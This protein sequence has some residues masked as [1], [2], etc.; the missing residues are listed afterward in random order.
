MTPSQLL[1]A[2]RDLI[3]RPGATAAG[4]WPRTAA[5][6]ARQALEAAVDA[7]WAAASETAG[8]DRAAM[9]SQLICLPSYADEAVARQI[10]FTYAAL[11]GAC[12]F[13]PYELAPTATEL[14]RWIN[15]VET[16][17]T[18][19]TQAGRLVGDEF[20]YVAIG[21]AEVL[22]G[23]PRL[24][25]Q[26]DAGLSQFVDG[27]RQVAH[28]EAGNRTGAEMLL[29]GVAVAK[30]LDVAATWELE[31]PE[32]RFGVHQPES[33]DV[34]VEVRQFPGPIGARAAPAKPCDLHTCQF[35][36]FRQ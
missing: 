17:L 8:L 21:T 2:A 27:S 19:L 31:D 11:S 7:Q 24:A 5:L 9:R 20:I 28:G 14:S 22:P 1:A 25:Q 13:H 12:H 3:E 4:V 33:E 15:D 6:L 23:R 26:L 16:L 36:P 29:T 10:A 18:R 30:Y 35:L 32:F 34:F